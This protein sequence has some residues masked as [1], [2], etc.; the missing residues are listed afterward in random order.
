[1]SVP[2]GSITDTTISNLMSSTTYS[3]EVAAVNWVGTGKYSNPPITVEIPSSKH[4]EFE[5]LSCTNG[6]TIVYTLRILT[7]MLA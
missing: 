7:F 1:M 3:I 2:G 6:R 4:C 5:F